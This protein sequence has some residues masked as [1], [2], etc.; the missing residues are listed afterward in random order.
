MVDYIAAFY[1]YNFNMC[2]QKLY[3]SQVMLV[4]VVVFFL[5]YN[6]FILNL[7]LVT[8]RAAVLM[9]LSG[10]AVPHFGSAHDNSAHFKSESRTLT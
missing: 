9:M 4:V 7:G 5:R 2:L 8:F 3:K 1:F 10:T 6:V